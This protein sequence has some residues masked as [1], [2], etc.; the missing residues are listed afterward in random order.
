MDFTVLVHNDE[1]G[2][3]WAEV[4]ELPGCITQGDTEQELEANLKEV[5]ELFLAGLID[6]YV[7]GLSQTETSE[8]A[9]T[10]WH[11]EM[12]LKRG[13]AKARA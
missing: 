7:E 8:P 2:G 4:E 9:D 3:F 6:D 13:K 5:I 11:V 10:E 1:D 12:S